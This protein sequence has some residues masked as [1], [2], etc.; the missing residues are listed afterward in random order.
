VSS[1][2]VIPITCEFP[3]KDSLMQ[4]QH[5]CSVF[6]RANKT[7]RPF[8]EILLVDDSPGDVEFTRL[9]LEQTSPAK[10]LNVVTDGEEAVAFLQKTG[11][12][13]TAPRPDL[14]LLDWR[15]PKLDGWE[16]L[17][18]IKEDGGLRSIPVVV[19]SSCNTEEE[20]SKAYNLRAN[21]F[22]RKPV[23]LQG[24]IDVVRTCEEFWLRIVTLE[25]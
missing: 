19:L 14:I 22:V 15:L 9:A 12:Y 2:L 1:P 18:V 10:H 5:S 11:A 6:P 24:F 13:Q 17:S 7:Y 8:A 3:P 20:I 16:V 23:D 21:C 4:L 25:R